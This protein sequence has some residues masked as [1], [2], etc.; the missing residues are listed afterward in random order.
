MSLL[1]TFLAAAIAVAI[2]SPV[3][4]ED[5]SMEQSNNPSMQNNNPSM[6]TTTTEQTT[7]TTTSTTET[8]VS[9]NKATVKDLMKVKGINAAKAKAI[10]AYRKKHNGF[11]STDELSKVKG[12]QKMKPDTLRQIEDQVTVD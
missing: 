7:T 6:Q 1:R 4:A 8:K 2:A 10:I 3:F 11:T 12:F 9:L 5:N